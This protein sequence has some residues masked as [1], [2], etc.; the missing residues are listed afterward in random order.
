MTRVRASL[1]DVFLELTGSEPR[2]VTA[3]STSQSEPDRQSE[4]KE[5]KAE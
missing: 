5:E 1:E 3:P 2:P 4:A